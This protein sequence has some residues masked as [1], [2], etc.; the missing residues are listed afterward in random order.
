MLKNVE[1]IQLRSL[2]QMRGALDG[3]IKGR[4][5]VKILIALFLGIGAGLLIGPNFG[6][7]PENTAR[8]VGYWLAVPGHL[9]LGI[10]Q[11]I[12][13]PLIF[14]SVIRGLGASEDVERLKKLGLRVLVY[15]MITTTVAISIGIFLAHG[16]K[17][18]PVSY[19]HLTLPTKRI[20]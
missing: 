8:T 11:M 2:K 5:W 13:I 3:L 1:S 18:G 12:V 7:I 14:S 19:T 4:L 9:F 17:P 6:L 16:L 20:V 15:F 10:I